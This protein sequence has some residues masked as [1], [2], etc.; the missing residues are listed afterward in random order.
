MIDLKTLTIKKAHEALIKGDFSAV[1]LAETYL[2]EIAKKNKELNAYLEVYDDVLEQ[3]AEADK[4]LQNFPTSKPART[5][6]SPLGEGGLSN[7]VGIPLAVKDNILIKGR[8][9]GSASKILENYIASYDA[10][11]IAKL[12]EAGAV[13]LGR[14]NMDEFAMGSS[15]ENS[16]YGAT[17]N[18][19]DPSRVPG[20]SSGGSATAVASDMALA[21][22]GSDT[23]GSIRQPA[24][25]CG[26][27]GLKPTYGAVSRYGLMAMASS[28][29]QIG[30]IAKTVEDAAIIFN[31]VKVRDSMDSTSTEV[32]IQKSK[33]KS[34]VVGV[35]RAFTESQGV[36]KEVLANFNQS[37]ATLKKLGHQIQD[38]SLPTVGYALAAY[39]I[40][41]PAEA[42]ANL[43]R[44]DGVKYGF[45]KAGE[46]LL[47]DYRL[48]RGAG[49]GR[50]VRRRI[51]LG[52]HVLSSGYYDAYYNKAVNA[53]EVIT[54]DF[55]RVFETVDVVATPTTPTPAF[56]LGD[57]SSDPL[58]M[59]LGDIFTVSANIA[60][61][62]AISVP[63]GFAAVAGR[64]LPLGLQF[65]APAG[66]EA[67]LFAI[68]RAFG[69]Q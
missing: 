13:F 46:N 1:E 54:A 24:S 39:Y 67:T 53:R 7:L 33:V 68:G 38:I 40:I 18:P 26:V 29:D 43:A 35:P 45:H 5:D 27:V 2:E 8:R 12:K 59:Y 16:A 62:P 17:K 52:T 36:D 4:K 23:G 42:S 66:G 6:Q 65:M 28:L 22:L 64:Q 32:K 30:P 9:A 31:C 61:L 69:G 60:S 44:F 3:A 57:K 11:V 48:S 10:T 63:S 49:F 41:M 20:G 55:A 51:I 56:K 19:H 34:L 15:T 21:A 58:A 25:F 50:E 14:T 47:E 37:L